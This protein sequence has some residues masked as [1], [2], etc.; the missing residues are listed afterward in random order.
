MGMFSSKLVGKTEAEFAAFGGMAEHI[1]PL[2]ERIGVYWDFL[3]RPDL[4]GDDHEVP[5]SAAFVS[6]MVNLGG[7]NTTF[8]YSAQ[9]SVYFYR[10]INDKAIKKA[11]AFWGYR[12]TEVTIEPGDILGMNRSGAAPI[13]YDWAMTHADYLSHADIVV[14]VDGKSVHAIGGNVGKKPGEVDRKSFTFSG[15][16]LLDK[17]KKQQVF[18]VIRNFLP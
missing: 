14:A 11:S 13:D 5:W 4:D 15:Q 6:Y 18:V 2:K 8:P 12:V 9:H 7:A 1:S 10:T 16:K 17:S 3:K